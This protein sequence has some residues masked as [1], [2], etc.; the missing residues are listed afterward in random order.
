[1]ETKVTLKVEKRQVT[2]KKVRRLRREGWVPA[3]VYGPGEEPVSVQIPR[4][5]AVEAY[6]RAGSSTMVDLLM[7]RKR[8]PR[9]AFIREAQRD[10]ITLQILHMDFHLVDPN[11]PITL[12]V[13]VVFVGESPAARQGLGVLTHGIEAVEVHCLPGD[14]PAR[15]EVD[16]S[17]LTLVDQSVHVRDLVVPVGVQIRSEPDVVLAYV[18][19]MRR[20]EVEEVKPEEVAV[21]EVEAAEGE[22]GEE[23]K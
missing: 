3:T 15:F 21:E 17:V 1:M 7:E 23:E 10:P 16:L 9:P 19:A 22:E 18:A 14:V 4:N 12:E 6:R 20:E 2:G 13:P 8:Q 11:R 5:Q